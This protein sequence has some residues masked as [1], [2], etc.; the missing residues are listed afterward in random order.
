MLDVIFIFIGKFTC[1]ISLIIISAI[2]YCYLDEK[3]HFSTK[4]VDIIFSYIIAFLIFGFLI[5]T[6][7]TY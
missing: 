5:L 1:V 7:S 4:A 2:C 6:N 3:Y